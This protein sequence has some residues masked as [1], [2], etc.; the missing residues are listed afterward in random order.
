MEVQELHRT[1]TRQNARLIIFIVRS[2]VDEA[3]WEKLNLL[4]FARPPPANVPVTGNAV[5]KPFRR[6]EKR[7]SAGLGDCGH[8]NRKT[9]PEGAAGRAECKAFGGGVVNKK[10][11]STLV[12]AAI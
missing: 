1:A 12:E 8:D 9:T 6:P 10:E 11:G 5:A 2:P 3:Q 4:S 7:G